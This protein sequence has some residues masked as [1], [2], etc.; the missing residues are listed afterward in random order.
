MKTVYLI[1]G[2]LVVTSVFGSELKT[3]Q[4][5]EAEA[6]CQQG[7]EILYHKTSTVDTDEK[8]YAEQAID[9][10]E[11]A[12]ALDST[13][14]KAYTYLPLSYWL[15][16]YGGKMEESEAREKG[17]WAA[18]KAM[19]LE[20][21]AS[22]SIVAST[23]MIKQYTTQYEKAADM[24]RKAV[25]I[26]PENSEAHREL[27]WLY[28][29]MGKFRDA[30]PEAE[31][32]CKADPKSIE[33][34][35]VLGRI[36]LLLGEY[37]QAVQ[38]YDQFLAL[39]PESLDPFWEKTYIYSIAGK[40]NEGEELMKQELE[41]HPDNVWLKNNLSWFMAMQGQ[42]EVALAIA[43]ETGWKEE[44][45]WLNA[46]LGHKEKALQIIEE[47]KAGENKDRWWQPWNIAWIYQGMGEMD[48]A[49]ES[50]EEALK[51][52]KEQFPLNLTHWG[53]RLANDPD[54]DELRSDPR[55]QAI[56]EQTGYKPTSVP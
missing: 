19:A 29:S 53:W 32:A 12:I 31:L 40:Y 5:K 25:K 49:I 42:T 45:G 3:E 43:E 28:I 52:Q 37:D 55:F 27:A 47:L 24:L 8:M 51:R 13:Y 18:E 30:L 15:V 33:A 6:L 1:I 23:F 41:K 17:H 20:P 50:L 34:L 56:I 14:A 10:F 16:F 38:A 44:E 22:M 54:Y 2:L 48:K 39:Q 35:Y 4:R 46:R 36:H 7:Y 26:E 21:N 9:L 11:Q